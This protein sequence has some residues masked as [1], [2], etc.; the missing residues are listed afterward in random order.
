MQLVENV[1]VLKRQLIAAI[2]MV[3]ISA[4]INKKDA[5]CQMGKYV[6]EK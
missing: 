3:G 6:I 4:Y 1:K 2:L 5:T